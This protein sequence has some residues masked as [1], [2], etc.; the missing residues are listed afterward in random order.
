MIGSRNG[1]ARQSERA[2]PLSFREQP[3]GWMTMQEM[4]MTG[5]DWLVALATRFAV[6]I[7]L[8]ALVERLRRTF[9]T[10]E[11][12]RMMEERLERLH[13]AVLSAGVVGPGGRERTT[14]PAEGMRRGLRLP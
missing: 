5:P 8:L 1:S 9:A 13:D 11:E 4:L 6:D 12:V 7:L 10:R 14:L 2:G 3:K